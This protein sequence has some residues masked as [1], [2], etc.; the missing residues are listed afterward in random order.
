MSC[1]SVIFRVRFPLSSYT[2]QLTSPDCREGTPKLILGI[3][4]EVGDGRQGRHVA[5]VS[6]EPLVL[7][8]GEPAAADLRLADS[9]VDFSVSIMLGSW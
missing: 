2:Y 9:V 7:V 4:R 3:P 5:V 6:R 1:C 8:G